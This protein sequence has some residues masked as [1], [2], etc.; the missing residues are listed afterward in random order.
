MAP[1]EGLWVDVVGA[2]GSSLLMFSF[3][4]E[5]VR[6]LVEGEDEEE[7]LADDGERREGMQ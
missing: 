7:V 6:S 3:L 1:D 5:V 4:C 2:C